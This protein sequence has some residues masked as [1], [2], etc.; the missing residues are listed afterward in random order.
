[1]PNHFHLMARTSNHFN[2]NSFSQRL[3]IMLRSY[4]R[5][6]QIQQGFVGS[7]F[8]QNTKMKALLS[9]QD[10]FN[11]FQY[12]HQNPVEA[13]L[14]VRPEQWEYSSFNE[15][16]FSMPDFCNVKLGRELLDLPSNRKAFYRQSRD[17]SNKI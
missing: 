5:G 14:V 12:I 2:P 1:M 15:Y 7:L 6:L 8:Q 4:T 9:H 11:C 16:L 10:A 3:G 17:A 13:K